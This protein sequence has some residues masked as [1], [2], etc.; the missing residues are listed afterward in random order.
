MCQVAS[1]KQSEIAAL[2]AMTLVMMSDCRFGA[3]HM[4]NL[5][6]RIAIIVT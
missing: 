5:R 2:Q 3:Y 6:S 4:K 1:A